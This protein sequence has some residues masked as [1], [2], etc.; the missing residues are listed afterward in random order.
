MDEVSCEV[1]YAAE[2]PYPPV[3]VEGKNRQ[4]AQAIGSNVGGSASE[5]SAVARYFYSHVTVVG[6]EEVADCLMRIAVVEMRHLDIFARLARQ[7]GEDPRLW[8]VNRG[9]RRYW[10]PEYLRYPQRVDQVLRYAL[11][12]EKGTIQK[13]RQQMLWIRD[14]NVQANLQRIIE[15]EE[16]H[17]KLLTDLLA[18]YGPNQDLDFGLQTKAIR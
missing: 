7:L 14:N 10:T 17:V 5:M 15:D 4:Y 6:C 12:E 3:E 1:R 2:G 16:V 18:A 11:E 9:G 8:A 13:Y